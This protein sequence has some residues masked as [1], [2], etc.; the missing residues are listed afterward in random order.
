MKEKSLNTNLLVTPGP[1]PVPEFAAAAMSAPIIHHRHEPFKEILA[2]VR[3]GLQHLF[4]TEQQVLTFCSSGTGAMEGTITNL[5]SSGDKALVIEGGKFGERWGE[6][7]R[8]YGV[9]TITIDVE[10]GRAADPA[11][12]AECLK[13]QPDIRAVLT[14][15]TET[16]T[17]VRHPI[18]EIAEVVKGYDQTLMVVDAITGLGVYDIPF[19]KW[20]LDVVVTGSQKALMLPPGLAFACLS[21]KAWAATGRSNLPKY[22]FN[23][24]KERSS[25][26]KGQTAYTPAITL[27]IGL[28]EV[29]RYFQAVGLKHVF[30]RTAILAEAVRAAMKAISLEIFAEVPSESLTAVKIPDS[31]DGK[32]VVKLLRDGHGIAVAG[33][34]AK[35]AGRIIRIAHMGWINRADIIATLAAVELVLK[36]LGHPVEL[37]DGVRAAMEVFEKEGADES[38]GNG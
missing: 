37:G 36:G 4:R 14:Q 33:G 7:C 29:L 16:S 18:R 30:A 13:A 34:Q 9:E 24:R 22:Y 35:L 28:R 19:D 1:T 11:K 6:I 21:E 17:G 3:Q 27:L 26:E 23:F 10:W 15:A 2:E 20:G 8:T 31:I 12:V 25:M 5:L 38:S 32:E